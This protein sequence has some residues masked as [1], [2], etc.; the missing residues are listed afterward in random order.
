MPRPGRSLPLVFADDTNVRSFGSLPEDFT[1]RV[2]GLEWAWIS[3]DSSLWEFH[4]EL[5]NT[6]SYRKFARSM[7]LMSQMLRMRV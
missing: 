6:L 2:L 7:A 1:R 4:G 5:N 3:D